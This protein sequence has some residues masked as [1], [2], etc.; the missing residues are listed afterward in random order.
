MKSFCS[1]AGIGEPVGL[2]RGVE[3]RQYSIKY[4]D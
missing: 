3:G 4:R 2:V 1:N